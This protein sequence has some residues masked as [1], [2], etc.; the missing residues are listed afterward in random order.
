MY[1]H[2][3]R[4]VSQDWRRCKAARV[5]V[6]QEMT[7]RSGLSRVQCERRVD[8]IGRGRQRVQ[9]VK[10][11]FIAK[12][13]EVPVADHLLVPFL[14]GLRSETKLDHLPSVFTIHRTHLPC[15]NKSVK[16]RMEDRYA[17]G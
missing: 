8:Q 11:A 6:V 5:L 12:A 17:V 2:L 9:I 7:Q 10:G 1:D 4:L 3:D 13:A 15:A 14:C 16:K